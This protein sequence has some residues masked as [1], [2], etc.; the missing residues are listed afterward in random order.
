M[1]CLQKQILMLH[2]IQLE[3]WPMVLASTSAAISR[4]TSQTYCIP[5]SF[6]ANRIFQVFPHR[7]QFLKVKLNNCLPV[8]PDIHITFLLHWCQS[9][10]STLLKKRVGTEKSCL[11]CRNHK[12]SDTKHHYF[13]SYIWTDHY[14]PFNW[15]PTHSTGPQ[16]IQLVPK[17][18]YWLIQ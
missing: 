4:V 9:R 13:V 16:S 7:N 17:F 14:N 18:Q 8:L 15:S 1:I 11:E 3:G 6:K 12:V 2:C 10:S 5:T